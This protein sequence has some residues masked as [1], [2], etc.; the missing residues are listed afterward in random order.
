MKRSGYLFGLIASFENLLKAARKA[1]RGK[2]RKDSTAGFNLNLENELLQLQ[3]ELQSRAYRIGA[4]KCFYVFDPR[5]RLI[6][7]LP[8]RDRVVQHA[9]CNVIEP[10]FD[11]SIIFDSYA[12]RKGNGLVNFGCQRNCISRV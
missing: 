3:A 11:G 5:R 4:Y 10:I 6:S 12:C 7:A 2:R 9:L 1:Q 8:Y